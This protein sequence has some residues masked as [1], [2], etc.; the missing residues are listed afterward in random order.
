MVPGDADEA[1]SGVCGGPGSHLLQD[2]RLLCTGCSGAPGGRWQLWGEGQGRSYRHCRSLLFGLDCW[3]GE[4]G[5]IFTDIGPLAQLKSFCVNVWNK[6]A[7]IFH[8]R[9]G[10][11][12][13]TLTMIQCSRLADTLPQSDIQK[14]GCLRKKFGMPPVFRPAMRNGKCKSSHGNY[15]LW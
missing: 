3:T 2:L 5:L 13:S 14:I 12:L 9:E 15:L 10:V 1:A 8:G 7:E 11:V 4:P 6:I